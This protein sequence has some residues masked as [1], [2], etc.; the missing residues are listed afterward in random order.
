MFIN[1]ENCDPNRVKGSFPRS[2]PHFGDSCTFVS[3][4][5]TIHS[6]HSLWAGEWFHSLWR[7][8]TNHSLLT[9]LFCI[10]LLFGQKEKTL[11]IKWFQRFA[12][13]CHFWL[14]PRRGCEYFT[15]SLEFNTFILAKMQNVPSWDTSLLLRFSIICCLAAARTLLQR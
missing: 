4:F 10:I 13:F 3:R 6:P 12:A 11:K 7:P 8:F 5:V 9:V 1:S 2:K 15:N 14:W